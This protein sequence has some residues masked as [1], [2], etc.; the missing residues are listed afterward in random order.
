MTEETGLG[1]YL[2]SINGTEGSGWE[3]FLNGGRGAL[4][5]DDAAVDSTVIVRWSL[6]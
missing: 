2:L 3:Y 4:A 1:L 5:V 6:A